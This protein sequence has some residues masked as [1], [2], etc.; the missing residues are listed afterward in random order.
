MSFQYSCSIAS[1]IFMRFSRHQVHVSRLHSFGGD[2]TCLSSYASNRT[3]RIW[4]TGVCFRSTGGGHAVAPV[5]PHRSEV[6]VHYVHFVISIG[7][8]QFGNRRGFVLD[9]HDCLPPRSPVLQCH[10]SI[11]ESFQRIYLR[12]DDWSYL[13]RL[14]HAGT[15]VRIRGLRKQTGR[16][17]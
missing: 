8:S 9:S 3:H 2:S 1:P 10:K 4:S 5:T 17:A 16:L 11:G 15:R 12:V 7:Y 14:E 13:P 6:S